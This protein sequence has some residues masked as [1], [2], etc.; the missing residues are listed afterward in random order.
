MA[1][2]LI[3]LVSD[4]VEID[5]PEVVTKSWPGYWEMLEDLA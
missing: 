3:G 5:A 1:L 2:A 4:G